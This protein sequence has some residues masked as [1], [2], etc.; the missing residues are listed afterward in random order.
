L[1]AYPLDVRTVQPDFV[2][3]VGHK[4]LLGP[5]SLGYFYAAP[6][7]Q[8][9][10][11]P[12]EYSWLNRRGSE[13]AAK[14]VE[15]QSDY[16]PGAR[17]FDVGAFPNF[18]LLPMAIAALEQ[19]LAWKI[20]LIQETLAHL[21]RPLTEGA[22]A[23]GYQV[24][25]PADRVGHLMGIRSKHAF[26]QSLPTR[27]AAERVFISFRGDSIRVAPHLYNTPEDIERL[28]AILHETRTF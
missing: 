24:A 11:Q 9:E 5:Y 2:V 25:A 12:I 4:W 23:L 15:Y 13:D 6:R 21:L 28:L 17:R 27:L 18:V 14:L 3:S 22:A 19:L 8:Q 20:P 10:G 7:W 26:S 1:G 16:R